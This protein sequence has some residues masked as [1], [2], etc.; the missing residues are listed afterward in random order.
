MNWL[1][2]IFKKPTADLLVPEPILDAYRR[3]ASHDELYALTQ[4]HCR[5]ALA[6]KAKKTGQPAPTEEP[7]AEWVAL[8]LDMFLAALEDAPVESN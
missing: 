3:G 1:H 2:R 5:T 8:M 6:H 7:E 4:A